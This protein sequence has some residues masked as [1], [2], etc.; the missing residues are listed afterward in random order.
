MRDHPEEADAFRAEMRNI[1]EIGARN[2]AQIKKEAEEERERKKLIKEMKNDEEV[3]EALEATG[4]SKKE[5]DEYL[6]NIIEQEQEE[7]RKKAVK[8]HKTVKKS[9][10]DQ[11]IEEQK[12]LQKELTERELH[13]ISSQKPESSKQKM[14]RELKKL[15][16]KYP[17]E[18]N[19]AF[20]KTIAQENV[21]VEMID[22]LM[23]KLA[24]ENRELNK[25]IANEPNK[26]IR[27]EYLGR[28]NDNSDLYETLEEQ[29]YKQTKKH[30]KK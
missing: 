6:G 15:N 7:L 13:K 10:L 23:R 19:K 29:N 25:L 14:E 3:M 21:R 4:L 27:D 9:A 8:K 26:K 22:E 24:A 28:L 11:A 18:H 12:K 1:G 20:N 2:R 30:T 16:D 17:G 5:A